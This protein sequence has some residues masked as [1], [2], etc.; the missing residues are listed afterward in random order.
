MKK[1]LRNYRRTIGLAWLIMVLSLARTPS[2]HIPNF[3]IPH[4]DKI[5]HF[6]MYFLLTSLFLYEA[7]IQSI[8]KIDAKKMLLL[9]FLLTT[10]Y[11]G[12][13][14]LLQATLSST[15]HGDW[16]D[17]LANTAGVVAAILFGKLLKTSLKVKN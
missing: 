10:F 3:V 7:K 14:E 13:M 17:F 11:G 4:L 6:G 2:T 5:L 1:K 15:R 12:L 9:I 16:Y 8:S